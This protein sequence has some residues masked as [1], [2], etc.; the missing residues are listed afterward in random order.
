MFGTGIRFT[1]NVSRNRWLSLVLVLAATGIAQGHVILD[2]PNG[3]EELAAGT[4]FTI[5]WHVQISHLSMTDWDLRYSITG[6]SGPWAVIA[7][8]LPA[9]DKTAGSVHTYEWTVP[10]VTTSQARVKV[11]MDGTPY[12]DISDADFSIVPEPN[13]CGDPGTVY[14]AADISLDCYVNSVD[15]A[16]LASGWGQ[17]GCNDPLWCNGADINRDGAVNE[18]D[19]LWLADQWLACTDPAEPFCDVYY[20]GQSPVFP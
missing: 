5:I 10:A 2:S 15:F 13:A 9:G 1:K 16:I 3:G 7:L 8:D 18:F 19:L 6:D 11:V 20:L 14:L 12:N 17:S 4:K